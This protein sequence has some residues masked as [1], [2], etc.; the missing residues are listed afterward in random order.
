MRA[1]AAAALAALV[2]AFAAGCGQESPDLFEVIRTGPAPRLDLVVNDDGTVTCNGKEKALPGQLLLRARKASRD[3]GDQADLGLH[4]PP[5]H[6]TV[7]SYRVR[8]QQ[9]EVSFADTSARQPKAFLE[10]QALTKDIAEQVCGL[11]T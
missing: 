3:L 11:H 1:A 9:G 7:F 8:V 5:G 10:T 6:G 4:L 2:G